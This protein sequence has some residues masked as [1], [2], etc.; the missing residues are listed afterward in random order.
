MLSPAG[1]L[2]GRLKANGHFCPVLCETLI[3]VD[4][5]AL[6]LYPTRLQ[7]RGERAVHPIRSTDPL[8]DPLKPFPRTNPTILPWP[9][10]SAIAGPYSGQ[11][12]QSCLSLC[13][14]SDIVKRLGDSGDFNSS[15]PTGAVFPALTANL[16]QIKV[17]GKFLCAYAHKQKDVRND[18]HGVECTR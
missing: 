8:R 7:R 10:W 17:T 13:F 3:P 4:G 9:C 14:A 12:G 16:T 11:G 18:S 15:Q 1:L 6:P 5:F 2:A